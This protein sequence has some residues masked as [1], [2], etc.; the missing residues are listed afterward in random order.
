M[1]THASVWFRRA[2]NKVSV[3]LSVAFT[4]NIHIDDAHSLNRS[5]WRRP[6]WAFQS[7]FPAN[8]SCDWLSLFFIA[9][10]ITQFGHTKVT[11]KMTILESCW[12][13]CIWTNNV[14]TGSKATAYYTVVSW[15][16]LFFF[17]ILEIRFFKYYNNFSMNTMNNF[18][19]AFFVTNTCLFNCDFL[20][21]KCTC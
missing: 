2:K 21:D 20:I 15:A 12:S 5:E 8:L 9:N 11:C 14:K 4:D 10:P 1:N 17:G 18:C 19:S 6:S 16:L 7:C 3:H 13:P